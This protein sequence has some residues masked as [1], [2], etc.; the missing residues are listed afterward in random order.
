M[1][2]GVIAEPI[3]NVFRSFDK[4]IIFCE[5]CGWQKRFAGDPNVLGR[6][7]KLNALDYTIVGVM[8]RGFIGTELVYTPEIWVP[9]AMQAQIEPGHAWLDNWGTHNIWVVGRLKPVITQRQAEAEL[10]TIAAQLGRERPNENAGMKIILSPPGL[11][12]NALRG[13]I[14]GFA[15]VLMGVACQVL[16]MACTNL[17]SLLLAR[18]SDR[19]KEIAIRLALGARTKATDPAVAHR[20][21]SA[22]R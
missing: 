12:G 7:V 8:P 13:P 1:R 19:R 11:V 4:W 16:L 10:N 3:S 17:A 15:A 22:F 20:E 5:M 9:M 2:G 14:V 21:S 18:A 6:T